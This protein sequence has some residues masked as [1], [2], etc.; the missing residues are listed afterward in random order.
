[1]QY[2]QT[3]AKYRAMS[4]KMLSKCDA[5]LM[6]Q[7][8]SFA[9]VVD[10]SMEAP[11]VPH[12]TIYLL[13]K[14]VMGQL[15]R[16]TF[17][18]LKYTASQYHQLSKLSRLAIHVFQD[19]NDHVLVADVLRPLRMPRIL[20][21][22]QEEES[23]AKLRSGVGETPGA[24]RG[25]WAIPDEDELNSDEFS[26]PKLPADRPALPPHAHHFANYVAEILSDALR[27]WSVPG[28][29]TKRLPEVL[30]D[31]WRS[32]PVYMQNHLFVFTLFEAS[33][34]G[35]SSM[36]EQWHVENPWLEPARQVWVND[37][38]GQEH[39]SPFYECEML[40][41]KFTSF[42]PLSARTVVVQSPFVTVR[43]F[44]ELPQLEKSNF[45]WSYRLCSLFRQ[46]SLEMPDVDSIVPPLSNAELLYLE[47]F[48]H[49][50]RLGVDE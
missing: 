49:R 46:I 45:V 25:P 19:G 44:A 18:S 39:T 1:M 24:R 9:V 22:A 26:E 40:A 50:L 23:A 43:N 42:V 3:S 41:R 27:D 31:G 48:I 13:P 2:Y 20:A 33:T 35:R 30:H 21:L 10:Y 6:D 29:G 37:E 5:R 17:F 28:W 38:N 12:P 34:G 15:N 7:N 47:D 8:D 14:C 16:G 36:T 4:V 32:I 11:V